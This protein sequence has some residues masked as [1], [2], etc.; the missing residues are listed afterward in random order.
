VIGTYFPKIGNQF[1]R[2]VKRV[3]EIVFWVVFLSSKRDEKK[4][5]E[6]RKGCLHGQNP[7]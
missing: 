4:Q 5:K 2:D 1:H 3:P 6:G 7:V